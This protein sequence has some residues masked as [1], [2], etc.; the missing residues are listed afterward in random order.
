MVLDA[1]PHEKPLEE[2][3]K[4]I[5]HLRKKSQNNP[6]FAA[7][8]QRMEGKLE[9]LKKE[10]F[11]SLT[12]W[13]R[14]QICRHPRRP[15]SKDYIAG[16]SQHFIELS[17][18][19]TFRE[20]TALVGGLVEIE[21]KKFVI[22]GQ[23]KGRDTE[24]RLHRNFG[25]MSPEGYRK[26]LRL[27]KMAEKFKLP[28]ISLIDTPGASPNL[29]DEERGQGWAIARNLLEMFRVRT[30]IIV[31]VVGEG[32]SG[33]ALGIGIGDAIGM[34]EHAY[35]S[36]ISPEG[37]ASIL[38]K[39]ASKKEEAAKIL[40]LNAEDMLGLKIV[41]TILPEPIGG[42]HYAPEVMFKCVKE[43]I[44]ERASVLQK[45]PTDLLLEERYQKFRHL[46]QFSEPSL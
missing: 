45:I 9:E 41:D 13:Q 40:K 2:V 34:L 3:E 5:D 20:D 29:E 26:A 12:P 17:G 35:Y 22:M 43:F 4:A 1:L 31:V 32:C 11:S 23:E 27:M 30:P 36:V 14:V 44:L 15:H 28:V 39:D 18:D 42:A 24:S 19:R 8:I 25:M 37:C 16:M 38:W 46:G 6:L 10:I 21:G 7:E 33:G